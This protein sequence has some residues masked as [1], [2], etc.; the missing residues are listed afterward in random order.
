MKTNA[1]ILLLGVLTA[2]LSMLGMARAQ[3]TI[4]WSE[5][6]ES[7]AAQD[8]WYAI[9]A[10]WQIGVPTYGPPTNSLGWRAH[11]GTNCA[12]TILN[13][14]YTDDRQDLL[15]SSPILV[16][17][18]SL[19]P[20]L[21]FWHWW[22]FACNDFGQVQIST[23]NG[24]TWQALSPQYG[25]NGTG[26]NY[27]SSGNWRRAW[28]DL[29]P[30]AGQTIRLGLYFSSQSSYG[31]GVAP[32]W[33][34]DEMVIE[35]GPLPQMT[36]PDSFEDTNAPDRWNADYGV[37]EIGVPTSGPGG[38][39]SGSNCLATVLSGNYTDDRYSRASSQPFVVPATN[40]R[41]RFWHWWSFACNDFG[42][43]QISTNNGA[44][45]QALS[46]QYGE[47][48]SGKNYD[49]SGNWRRAWLDLTPYAGQTVR[50][51]FYFFSQSSYGCGAAPGWYVDEVTV[52]SG[53]LPQMTFPD[54]FEDT[55]APNRW[56]ADYGVWEI[57]VPTS[58][59]GS[60]HSGSNCLAT[61]LSGNYTDDRYSRASSQPIVVPAAN[62]NPRLRFWH[63]WSFAC[64][65]FG[66]V[67]IST[68]N[69]ATWQ[70]LSPQY[71]ENGTGK[72]YDS[73][74]DWTRAW[75]DLTPYAGQTV[76]LGF[77]FYSQSSYGCNAAAGWYV[78]EVTVESG[79]LAGFNPSDG[80]EDADA[81]NR[82]N[83]DYGVWQIGVP[84]S[85]PGSA[86][87]GSN[88]LATV[89][90]G[91]YT[92]DRYSREW[93]QP[94]VVPAANLN[95]RLRFWHWWN[96]N[97]ND[98]GQV[99]I[100]TNNGISWLNLTN[101]Q[102]TA[103]SSGVWAHPQL[104]LI[105][106]AGRTV[107]LGFYFYSESSYGCGVGPGW[108]VD[109]LALLADGLPP[110]I[111]TQPTNQTVNVQSPATFTVSATGTDPLNYQWRSNGVP[112]VNATNTVYSL[113][114]AQ[115][116]YQAGYDVVITNLYGSTTSLPPATLTVLTPA[117][118]SP[119]TNIV[120]DPVTPPGTGGYSNGVFTIAGSGEDIQGTADA[121]EFVCQPLTGDGQIVA[122]VTSLVGADPAAE[123]GIMFRES[124]YAGSAHAFLRV[125]ANT[126]VVFRRRLTTDV[127]SVDTAFVP[128]NHSWLR[129]MRMG[130]TFVAHCS[131]NGVN[132][133]YVWFTTINMSNQ[134]QAG[135]AVTAHHDGLFAT[136]LVDNV[137]IGALSPM[138]G[139]W[140]LPGPKFILG[141]EAG[142]Y[143][144]LQRVGGYKFLLGGVVGEYDTIKATTNLATPF[145]SWQS[146]VT[147]T[148]TYGVVPI[149][150]AGALTNKM[151][152]YRA[153]KIGP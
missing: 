125:N 100:S 70:A 75:L 13:G 105:P 40:P 44:T 33:Y 143:S 108:Y 15:I 65:D 54:S 5:N 127:Y 34:V 7:P 101:G 98:Y 121:F 21:R 55:N 116:S 26:K 22:S 31:C 93:S 56:N 147:V 63:W 46:P 152:Y 129:L 19:N 8:N 122:R 74:G 150:D 149:L 103:S 28:L 79:P 131:T 87:G 59:P 110:F 80:F 120:V 112:I 138:S 42:Q 81:P 123:A 52:E 128:T 102:Y 82:W 39:H 137:S 145:A 48:G 37:W 18:A 96:F 115:P 72:N 126:N 146:L 83:A 118:P 24:A 60:A 114:S 132:W 117:F 148:N 71:G 23:N 136:G 153:Q 133:E 99:Q 3:T 20:R 91:N 151:K 66:Q 36:F 95:P 68:N 29:T 119:W 41:L 90:S 14:T 50:L 47:N 51:G 38:A 104:D 4:T 113:A 62:L 16:P 142:G 1:R 57:G 94:F 109:D 69:G 6:W 86:H 12:A 64:N 77:Y 32:G 111:T 144:E 17:V 9:G 134:V 88:C 73:S 85:G 89:L 35:A 49:S 106:Y 30:F 10:T 124:I 84:T 78:D 11:Q 2:C 58:G 53:P 107:R 92:D 130:N 25:E 97:C 141:G 67:Q 139:T 76:R 140:P 43:V 27:D 45:W 135:L 61:I